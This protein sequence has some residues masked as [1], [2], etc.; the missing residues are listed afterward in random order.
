MFSSLAPAATVETADGP[1]DENYRL[2]P[3]DSLEVNVFNQAELSG[4]Y[5]L[6]G[7]GRFSMHL[8]GQVDANG[9]TAS[10]LEVELVSRLK[11]DYLVNPRVSVSVLSYRPFYIIGEV[12]QPSAYP[13]VD[14]MTYLNAIAIAGGYTYRAKKD[15]VYVTRAGDPDE[16]ELRLG[17]NERVQPGDIIRVDERM[18]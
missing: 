11:P 12:G 8:I 18:F 4:E 6:D 10:D 13:F 2:G 17:V 16:E 14:G 1:V 3:G 9:M 5:T 7:S 15:I